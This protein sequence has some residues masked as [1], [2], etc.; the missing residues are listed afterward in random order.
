M[1]LYQLY[2]MRFSVACDHPIRRR[3][4]L[5]HGRAA[6]GG[7]QVS[8]DYWLQLADFK[9]SIY[10]TEIVRYTRCIK[11]W[12]GTRRSHW[13]YITFPETYSSIPPKTEDCQ[14]HLEVCM[15]IDVKGRYFP[16]GSLVPVIAACQLLSPTFGPPAYH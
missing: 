7:T 15:Y 14:F 9:T 10:T 2:G 6:K 13:G 3:R 5:A 12:S 8:R 4:Y 11:T 16:D 1:R